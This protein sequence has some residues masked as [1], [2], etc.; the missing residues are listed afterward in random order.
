MKTALCLLIVVAC[1]GCYTPRHLDK[2]R[3]QRRP[4]QVLNL[5]AN[6]GTVYAGVDVLGVKEALQVDPTG[7]S[8]A[9]GKDTLI[10]VGTALGAAYAASQI[11]GDDGGSKAKAAPSIPQIQAETVIYNQGSGSVNY[12]PVNGTAY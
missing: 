8:L 2:L 5:S 7:T 1:A 12:S 9:L 3:S 4:P 11:D 6:Q 10:A